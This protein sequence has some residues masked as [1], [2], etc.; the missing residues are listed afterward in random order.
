MITEKPV[1]GLNYKP[2]NFGV[3]NEIVKRN[4]KNSLYEIG[5]IVYC[6]QGLNKFYGEVI[7]FYT[8]SVLVEVEG[9]QRKVVSFK[10]LRKV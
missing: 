2:Y 3:D 7:V 8:N 4:Y 1:M 9:H 10:D 5:E 6:E